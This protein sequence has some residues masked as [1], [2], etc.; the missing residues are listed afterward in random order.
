MDFNKELTT[1]FI[2]IYAQKNP[3]KTF[4]CS[5]RILSYPIREN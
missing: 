4:N 3:V 1:L 5:D 2:S